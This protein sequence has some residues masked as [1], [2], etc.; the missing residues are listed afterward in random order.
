[1]GNEKSLRALCGRFYSVRHYDIGATRIPNATSGDFISIA[2]CL[3]LWCSVLLDTLNSM[4]SDMH[5]TDS[6][7]GRILSGM[8]LCNST[9]VDITVTLACLDDLD[10]YILDFVKCDDCFKDSHVTDSALFNAELAIRRLCCGFDCSGVQSVIS[11]ISSGLLAMARTGETC[12]SDCVG[13][14]HQVYS[15]MLKLDVNRPDVLDQTLSDYLINESRLADVDAQYDL[16]PKVGAFIDEMNALAKETLGDFLIVALN[17]RHGP[18]AV[19]NKEVK[20]WLDKYQ[21]AS[22]DSRVDYVI[23]KSGFGSMENYFPFEL[24]GSSTRTSRFV[25][26]PK[27]WKKLRGIS[28]EPVEL[29]YFQQALREALDV[30]F[31]TNDWWRKRVDLHDQ[32]ISMELARVGSITKEYATLD[33]SAAS[34]SVSLELVK[35]VFKG[36]PVL[37]WLLAT[38]STQ[39]ILDGDPLR[40]RKFA[41]M[42]SACCFPVECMIFTL[43]AEVIGNR[44][45]TEVDNSLVVRVYGDD[46]IVNWYAAEGVVHWLKKLGFKVNERKSC[47]T[48]FFREACGAECVQ[49]QD[50][51]SVRYKRIDRAFG[52]SHTTQ[53]TVTKILHYANECSERGLH[54]TRE[55]LLSSLWEQHY[56]VGTTKVP[57]QSCIPVTF[58]GAHGSMRSSHPTNFNIVMKWDERLQTRVW[59][60]LIWRQKEVVPIPESRKNDYDEALYL[61]WLIHHQDGLVDW[62]QRWAD[63][64]LSSQQQSVIDSRIGLGLT[65]VPTSKW[66]PWLY[67]FDSLI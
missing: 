28:A 60:T 67:E 23:R 22:Y 6:T 11:Q 59:K 14:L 17:P 35:R 45:T 4:H 31:L 48:G 9:G 63:G 46:I 26:V 3:T 54:G 47:T 33:L 8:G 30:H 27:S 18:G 51:R 36:T 24:T 64:W 52:S 15:F 66:V 39:T 1:M 19:A 16:D 32:G 25:S 62:E 57:V 43:I 61:E 29:Q 49:G 10:N 20:C 37:K 38:R 42:G 58:D 41:P 2:N 65:M 53:D 55:Y 56:R 50:V 40:I 44:I 12:F 13:L 21:M 7:Q 5:K 34:D